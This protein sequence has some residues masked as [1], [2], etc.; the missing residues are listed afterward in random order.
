MDR[1][2]AEG[3]YVAEYTDGKRQGVVGDVSEGQGVIRCRRR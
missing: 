1:D 2:D 3:E